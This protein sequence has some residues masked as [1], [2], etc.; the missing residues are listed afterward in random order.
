MSTL[1][2]TVTHIVV[3]TQVQ[4]AFQIALNVVKIPTEMELRQVAEFFSH[5]KLRF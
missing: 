4:E 2:E 1:Q 5:D 3:T